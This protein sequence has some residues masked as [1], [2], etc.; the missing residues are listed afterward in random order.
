MTAF[1]LALQFLT[2]IPL[3]V[4]AVDEGRLARSLIFFPLAGLTIG[5]ILTGVSSLLL[6]M[7]F[8]G[9]IL[10]TIIVVALVIITAG[11][12]LDGLADTFDAVL[13]GGDKDEMLKVMRDPHIGVMGVI[14]IVCVLL[15][16]IS[17]LSSMALPLRNVSLVLM[18]VLSRWSLVAA[19]FFF[20]Y[21][22]KEGKAKIFT[23]NINLR[24]FF[25]ATIITLACVLFFWQLKGLLVFL[26]AAVFALL[27]CRF[28]SKR[29]EGITGD[30]LGAINELAEVFV[31]FSVCIL[32][33][34]VSG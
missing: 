2:I 1:L 20:P 11:I 4:K 10:G 13:S 31:L 14:S 27:A 19:M 5:L 9:L 28:I 15:L 7:Q 8:S 30:S 33:G 22:R 34:G 25:L 12:H 6:I 23:E 29:L 21:A 17:L 26:S 16:K 3:K 32:K 24:I 18:C